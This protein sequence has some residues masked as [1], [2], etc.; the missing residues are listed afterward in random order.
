MGARERL[1]V[2][3]Y[4]VGSYIDALQT[5]AQRH[6]MIAGTLA[7]LGDTSV[8]D[9]CKFSEPNEAPG[10]GPG[11]LYDYED[12]G[13]WELPLGT[14]EVGFNAYCYRS[15]DCGGGVCKPVEVK[16]KNLLMGIVE[17]VG[18]AIGACQ[19]EIDFG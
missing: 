10:L 13:A 1:W 2:S 17:T 16:G 8:L 12:P 18:A 3:I 9:E 14:A 19:S 11:S 6:G 4:N 5:K 15:E 7:A